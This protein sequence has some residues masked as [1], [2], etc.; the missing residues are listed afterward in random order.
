MFPDGREVSSGKRK[1]EEMGKKGNTR[2]AKMLKMKVREGVRIAGEFLRERIEEATDWGVKGEKDES[3]GRL[4]MV[5]RT[6][7]VRGDWR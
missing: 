4:W 5:R 3:R 6:R 2:G 7:R 1:I